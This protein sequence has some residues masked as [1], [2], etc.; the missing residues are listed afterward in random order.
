MPRLK[1]SLQMSD[2]PAVRPP[3]RPPVCLSVC[4]VITSVAA[5]TEPLCV[6]TFVNHETVLHSA[7]SAIFHLPHR[8]EKSI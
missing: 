6:L 2:S 3:A 5:Q 4:V 7:A 1:T 8:T